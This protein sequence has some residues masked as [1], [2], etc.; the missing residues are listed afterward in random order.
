M[1]DYE[2]IA[3][4]INKS[5]SAAIDDGLSPIFQNEEEGMD[6]VSVINQVRSSEV[7][8]D[9]LSSFT[10]ESQ[11]MII[12]LITTETAELQ[13]LEKTVTAEG[14]KKND[15]RPK[16]ETNDDEEETTEGQG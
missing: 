5:I 15:E 6:I 12:A 14:K 7:K 2:V 3:G 9:V 11:A 16:A 8:S 4:N 1:T 10:M 13:E